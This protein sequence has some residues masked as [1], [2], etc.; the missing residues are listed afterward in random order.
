VNGNLAPVHQLQR[1]AG[2]LLDIHGQHEQQ[3]L[4]STQMQLDAVDAFGHLRNLRGR[5]TAAYTHWRQQQQ[6]F[7]ELTRMAADRARQ[8]ELTRYQWRELEEADLQPDEEVRLAAERQRLTHG[9]RLA[10]LA[11]LTYEGLYGGEPSVSTLLSG[12]MQRLRELA[13]IDH[14]TAEWTGPCEAA[15]ADLRDVAER[16]RDYRDAL[17]ENPDRLNEV[18]ERWDRLQR[19]KKKYGVDLQALVGLRERLRVELDGLST[20]ES[21]LTEMR[22]HVEQDAVRTVAL[23]QELSGARARAARRLEARVKTELA[24]LRMDQTR[25]KIQLTATEGA[26]GLGPSGRDRVE[27]LL[28]ANPGEPLQPLARVASGGE[29]SRVML[30]IKTVLAETDGVPILIFD[31]VDAGIGGGVAAVMGQRLRDLARYHQVFCITHLPQ[32]A[33]QAR[34]H[35]VVQKSVIKKRTLTRVTRLDEPG[36]QEEIARMLAGTT[37]TRSVRET[38]AEMIGKADEA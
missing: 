25:F 16:L 29:L 36:R 9:R 33:S 34:H 27:Y 12:A 11:E 30:G 4:L 26:E 23:A 17:D 28:S 20:A 37:I 32:V 15:L 14:S 10:E 5:Y 31:E 7:T 8:E 24:A 18:D 6:E 13:N 22:R 3:S 1:L 19:L 21:R 2:T 38:A 35:F